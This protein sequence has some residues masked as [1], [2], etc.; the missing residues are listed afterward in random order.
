VVEHLTGIYKAQGTPLQHWGKIRGQGEREREREREGEREEDLKN[1]VCWN[2]DF[3]QS[4][5][6]VE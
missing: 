1:G 6:S 4:S 2:W 5:S 3:A